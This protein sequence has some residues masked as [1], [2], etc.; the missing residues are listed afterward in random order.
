MKYNKHFFDYYVLQT[1]VTALIIGLLS[2]DREEYSGISLV[3][4]GVLMGIWI[5]TIMILLA[6]EAYCKDEKEQRKAEKLEKRK[7]SA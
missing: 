3:A 6:K 7:K 4:Y 5:F 1:A 2:V